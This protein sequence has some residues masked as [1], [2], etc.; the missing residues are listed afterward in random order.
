MLPFMKPRQHINDQRHIA[1]GMKWA[2]PSGYDETWAFDYAPE[3]RPGGY[4]KD[5][6]IDD[7]SWYRIKSQS[8]GPVERLVIDGDHVGIEYEVM[9]WGA[10]QADSVYRYFDTLTPTRRNLGEW[11]D[12]HHETNRIRDAQ[13]R[14]DYYRCDA[15][16]ARQERYPTRTEYIIL[17]PYNLSDPADRMRAQEELEFLQPRDTQMYPVV[18][19]EWLSFP[20]DVGLPNKDIWMTWRIDAWSRRDP[21]SDARM[22][23]GDT[24]QSAIERLWEHNR[25]VEVYKSLY[26][27]DFGADTGVALEFAGW[28]ATWL[29]DDNID[30]GHIEQFRDRV[31]RYSIANAIS[32]E[33]G[34]RIVMPQPACAGGTP[35]PIPDAE[36]ENAIG[37]F[38]APG[39]VHRRERGYTGER[40]RRNHHR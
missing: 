21:N 17:G 14:T 13:G 27:G 31:M 33:T 29:R 20:R 37:A 5:V 6:L 3:W 40:R 18:P 30:Q 24:A 23:P 19:Q 7:H 15:P 1:M 12:V 39:Y 32:I 35:P 34:R 28:Q 36:Y 16:T 26:V 11:N 22:R 10:P 2:T 25:A 38:S 9:S 4:I 8:G